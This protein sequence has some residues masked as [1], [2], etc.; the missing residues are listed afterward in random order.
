M[1]VAWNSSAAPASQANDT[2]AIGQILAP[3]VVL[4]A[5][6]FN[7]ILCFVD[8]KLFGI[9]A[10]A[11]IGCE[12]ML[13]ASAFALIWHRGAA[14]Y[15]ILSL[16]SAY[17]FTLMLI[18]SEFDPKILR[19]L[20]IPL[21]FYFMG[22]YLGSLVYCD[23]LV[24]LLIFL[25]LGVALV[26]WLALN[27]YLH[28]FNVIQYYTSRGTETN[29]QT[30]SAFGLFIRGTDTAAGLFINGTR[31]E[32]R[33]LLPFLGSHRVSGIFLE[34]VSVGN[35][36]AIVFAW[37]LL[38]Y[39]SGRLA[40]IA[41]I[42]AIA[43]I[44]VLADARF[45]FYLCILTLG[46]YLAA[47]T[48]RPTTLFAAPFVMM[49]ALAIYAGLNFKGVA[50]NTIAGRMLG[51]GDSL[52]N[53][54]LLQIFGLQVSHVFAGIYAGDSG[55]GY[56]LVHIGIVGFAAL[57]ALFVYAPVLDRDGWRF[58]AFIAF[59][60]VLLLSISASI[61]SIKTAALLWFLYGT[62]NNQDADP[63]TAEQS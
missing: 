44:L 3:L 20:L 34:P 63:W 5:V 8:T 21:V 14:L 47:P 35:F 15:A 62:L 11:V 32:E 42:L 49:V 6:L 55:Y 39:R 9:G 41:K 2:Q 31:F 33:T 43:A 46:V 28:Y 30:D 17:F 19:D 38:R 29:L 13:I 1:S 61:F 24:G 12:I 45:G 37:V 56:L 51:A 54:E 50:S 25:V 58:R 60:A 57:W 18:R 7:F 10:N 40:L 23:K 52:L 4:A 26:E 27:T 22:R 16:I 48:M 53:L 59:Y 36:G